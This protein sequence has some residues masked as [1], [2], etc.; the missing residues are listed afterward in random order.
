MG[1]PIKNLIC[2]SNDNDVLVDYFNTGIYNRNREFHKTNSPSMDILTSSNFE[3]FLYYATKDTKKVSKLMEELKNNGKY[4][5]K[6]PFDYFYGYKTN[7][8]DVLK[9]IKEVYNK[10]N[11][12]IDPHTACG[13]GAYLQNKNIDNSKMVILSTASI[14]KFPNTILKSFGMDGD[15]LELENKFN[16]IRPASLKFKDN[17][18]I[19]V[20]LKNLDNYL[21]KAIGEELW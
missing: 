7:E 4:E 5:F 13:Y 1:L 6:N 8:D 3:R 10:Y 19:I 9:Y 16:L 18:R 20:D 17:D 21:K 11:Y 2:A 14:F 12:L 15:V